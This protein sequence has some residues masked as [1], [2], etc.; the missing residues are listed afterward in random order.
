MRRLLYARIALV[1]GLSLAIITATLSF[2]LSVSD[3]IILFS[4]RESQFN[5]LLASIKRIQGRRN[6]LVEMYERVDLYI[7]GISTAQA[8]SFFSQYKAA[9]RKHDFQK[10]ERFLGMAEL[11]INEILVN[12]EKLIPQEVQRLEERVQESFREAEEMFV[13]LSQ[14]DQQYFQTSNNSAD[15][16][17]RH[18][19]LRKLIVQL[20]DKI[21]ERRLQMEGAIK[22]VVVIKQER[23]LNM[24]E[25]ENLIHTIP[26]S[27][28]RLGKETRTGEFKI[29]DKIEKVWGYYQ[30][31]MPYWMG[32]YF[33][34]S[35]ENGLHG[36][37]WDG[38]G[39]RYWED[40]IGV[41]NVTYGC[42]MANDEDMRKLFSWSEVGTPV[43]IID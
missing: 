23:K 31:W 16:H 15:D 3:E 20:A 34:G 18:R 1:L 17:E 6:A 5:V 14:L 41:N 22:S 29:L 11:S 36:I 19:V 12:Q 33:A 25:D 40:D 30:I 13:N 43:T 39:Y 4:V 9:M 42:V 35:S 8:D 27:L 37:P 10:A 28:G 32:V 2:S 26:I 7:P 21:S 24:Y 38:T